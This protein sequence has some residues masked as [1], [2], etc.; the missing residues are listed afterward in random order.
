MKTVIIDD[1]GEDWTSM[2]DFARY[3]G[4]QLQTVTLDEFVL[5]NMG[6]IRVTVADHSLI[7]DFWPRRVRP[8]ALARLL[9]LLHDENADRVAI[10]ARDHVAPQYLVVDKDLALTKLADLCEAHQAE[11]SSDFL[12]A[13]CDASSVSDAH[14]FAKAVSFWRSRLGGAA[15]TE[16]VLRLKALVHQRYVMVQGDRGDRLEL[17]ECGAGRSKATRYWISQALGSSPQDL[18]DT[19]YGSWVAASYRQTMLGAWP[20]LQQVDC[21]VEWPGE[22]RSRL[23]YDRLMLPLGGRT[24]QCSTLLVASLR[25]PMIDLRSQGGGEIRNVLN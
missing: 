17:I 14:P 18:A 10:N 22:G 5:K 8:I 11:R 16:D 20:T 6:F 23:T 4:V 21:I 13:R 24:G 1:E 25:N 15:S 12:F 3:L 2:P 7:V 19:A 9:Y